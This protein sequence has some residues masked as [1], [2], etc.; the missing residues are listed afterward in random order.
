M[1]SS[2]EKSRHNVPGPEV[3]VCPAESA[4]L[5]LSHYRLL[6]AIS[7][8]FLLLRDWLFSELSRMRGN[9]SRRDAWRVRVT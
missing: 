4:F 6:E 2:T 7:I 5:S 3:P 9:K 8:G 1:P